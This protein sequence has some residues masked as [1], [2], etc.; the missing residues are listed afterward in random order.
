MIED[1]LLEPQIT[2]M[3]DT[4]IIDKIWSFLL[5]ANLY[6][7]KCYWYVVTNLFYIDHESSSFISIFDSML[8]RD[9]VLQIKS[10]FCKGFRIYTT[11]WSSNF[12]PSHSTCDFMPFLIE[13][14][15]LPM[16]YRDLKIIELIENR[17][18]CQE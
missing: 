5:V 17:V 2:Y 9:N 15:T 18:Q 12:K 7:E 14:P 16:E 1:G 3:L 4:T 13:F 6:W 8:S 11:T 10:F